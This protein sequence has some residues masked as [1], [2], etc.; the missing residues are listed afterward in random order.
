L[1]VSGVRSRQVVLHSCTGE[2]DV[3]ENVELII[4]HN[5]AST[6][7]LLTS[8][9]S[10]PTQACA[11]SNPDVVSGLPHPAPAAY[12]GAKVCQ[13]LMRQHGAK[14]EQTYDIFG[15]ASLPSLTNDVPAELYLQRLATLASAL[16]AFKAAG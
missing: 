2:R 14:R 8:L 10:P 16:A 12:V 1:L 6:P 9:G 3:C 4:Q 13:A 7:P 15:V 5:P 11:S